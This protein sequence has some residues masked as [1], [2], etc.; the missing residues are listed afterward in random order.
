MQSAID[1]GARLVA[2][3]MSMEAMGITEDELIDCVELGGVAEFLG[4]AAETKTN[5]FI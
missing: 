3:T 2:C 4:A 1:S 5:L